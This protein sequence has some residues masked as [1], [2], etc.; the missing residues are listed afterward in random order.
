MAMN[1]QRKVLVGVLLLGVGGLGVDRFVIGTPDAAAA[2]DA[3]PI[4]Q[5]PP[6]FEPI[7]VDESTPTE[8]SDDPPEALPSYASLTERLLLAQ[9]RQHS[10][11][12]NEREDPFS[13]PA[14]WQADRSKPQVAPE[15]ASESKER[16]RIK[17]LFK[18]D[19][20]VRSVI[21]G[22]EEMLAVISGGGLN[23]R[24]IRIGQKVRVA[25]GNGSHEE[26]VLVEVG[27]RYVVWESVASNERIKMTVEEV[28]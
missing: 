1:K 18:L 7:T 25:D 15:V 13:L 24:A 2:D 16:V 10:D 20:T 22:K 5:T 21:D 3:A 4:E 9:E 14:Q 28:L 17:A 8:G 27:S 26:Y 23:A 19:G 11:N 12:S 6:A